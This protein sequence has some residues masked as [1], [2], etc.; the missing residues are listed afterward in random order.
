LPLVDLR[1]VCLVRAMCDVQ[2]LEENE[3]SGLTPVLLC[4]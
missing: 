4:G 3:F 1:A 2:R